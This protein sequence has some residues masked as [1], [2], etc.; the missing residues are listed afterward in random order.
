M[1]KAVTELKLDGRTYVILP[2][3]EYLRLRRGDAPPRTVDAIEHARGSLGAD[4]RAARDAAGLTQEDL[5]AKLGKCQSSVSQ[6][7]SGQV[8]VDER[9]VAAVLKACKLPKDWKPKK[10]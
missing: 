7:E 2:K 5:A 1:D 10:R 4:L 3:A 9:Y 8:S 6:A